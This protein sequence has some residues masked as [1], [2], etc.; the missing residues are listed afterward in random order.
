MIK[1]LDCLD[2][3]FDKKSNTYEV[4]IMNHKVQHIHLRQGDMMVRVLSIH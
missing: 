2:I 3:A 1:I 4:G